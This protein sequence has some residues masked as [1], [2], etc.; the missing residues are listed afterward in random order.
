MA[1]PVNADA[2][3][4]RA[5]ILQCALSQFSA[6]G[7]SGTSIRR[8][9]SEAG[10]SVAMVHHYFGSKSGLYEACIEEMYA[11]L[12]ALQE[13][14][15][16]IL[17]A[18]DPISAVIER[19]VRTGFRFAREHRVAMRLLWRQ[20]VSAGQLDAGRRARNQAPF[21]EA[22]SA[23]IGALTGQPAAALRLPLQTVVMMTSRYAIS[24]DA[25]LAFFVG[26]GV[27]APESAVEAHLVEVA[28]RLLVPSRPEPRG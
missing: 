10:V 27:T 7:L 28:L 18:G 14:L 20:V 15:P 22:V 24:D 9:A 4:T 25:E 21:L 5:R 12:G 16:A 3:A 26:D 19:A 23:G 1:R 11:E 13:H 6:G 17:G 2:A 8:I